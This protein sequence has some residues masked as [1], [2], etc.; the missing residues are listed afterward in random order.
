MQLKEWIALMLL[1]F[2]FL[3][4]VFYQH[5][6][7]GFAS[8]VTPFDT[9]YKTEEILKSHV[10][11]KEFSPEIAQRTLQNYLDELD[12][13]KVYFLE[14]EVY[15]YSNPPQELLQEVVISYKKYEFSHFIE[16]HKRF[17]KAIERR[18]QIE[19]KI[20]SLDLPKE[21]MGVKE[22][23]EL[24]WAKNENELMEKLLHI[25][26]IQEKSAEKLSTKEQLSLFLQ[27]MEKRRKSR[28]KE[29]LG[30]S[31]I[32]NRKIALT[33]FLKAIAPSLDAHTTYFTPNE[34]KQFIV[35]IEQRI[36]GIGVQFR[37]DLDG[38]TVMQIV[39][40]GPA[41]QGKELKLGDKIIAV[42]HDTIIGLDIQ[43]AA[44][45]I[46][47]P[48]GSHVILTILRDR[49]NSVE[50]FD[51]EILRDEIVLTESR[52][53]TKKIPY[54]DGIIGHISLHSFYHD[55]KYSSSK[56]V[57]DAIESMQKENKLLGV[58]L[59]LR[60]N[61]GGLLTEAV[62]ITSLFIKKGVVAAIRD[63]N[64]HVQ[65][66]RNLQ[67]R[68]AFQGPLI[69]LINRASASAAEIVALAL[70]D[71][72]RA[73]VC[74][75]TSYGKGSYQVFTLDSP[76]PDKINPS[77]EYKVT[78][79]LYY[80]VGGKSPQLTGVPTD[81]SVPGLLA[82]LDVGE[83]HNK[84]PLQNDSIEPLFHDDLSDINPLHR[85]RVKQHLKTGL[86]EKNTEI[87]NFV[88]LL[89]EHSQK[90]IQKNPTYQEFLKTIENSSIH[91][92]NP[93]M[94]GQTDLQLEESVQ[95]LKEWIVFSKK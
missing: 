5:A 3:G 62:E 67:D 64:F 8:S 89:S 47:G 2:V 52:Y 88:P 94:V 69:V 12:P 60:N 4:F 14:S 92:L 34:A 48:K 29:F 82:F 7:L 53:T 74:G 95:V 38:F 30:T 55:S 40:G 23:H 78:K 39:E 81:V 57:R 17:A 71:Y 24:G 73:I 33:C 42:N 86:E 36:F 9:Y 79:G 27:R 91:E 18:N 83:K 84:F 11:Y 13:L 19:K 21:P 15:I 54:G 58:L 20:A 22:I 56:D 77:G 25:R 44:D 16:I 35:Q 41:H 43:E 87:Q 76:H 63:H 68:V 80:T 45:L 26:A 51:I 50:Q 75:E 65:R 59:D 66:L 72:G 93:E 6:L 28:E 10:L 31:S 46:R 49:E 90:R 32:E 70:S 61:S 1:R 85:M 37:D